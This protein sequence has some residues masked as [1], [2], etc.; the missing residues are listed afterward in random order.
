[1]ES[2]ITV[3]NN[4][5]EVI[6]SESSDKAFIYLSVK[7]KKEVDLAE[8]RIDMKEMVNFINRKYLNKKPTPK[9]IE[10]IES[11]LE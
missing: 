5:S 2:K 1:M 10:W 7:I 4:S 6:I 3:D 11:K 9:W 8:L